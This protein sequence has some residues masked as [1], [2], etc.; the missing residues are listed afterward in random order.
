MAVYYTHTTRARTR[1]VQPLWS[2]ATMWILFILGTFHIA[3][4]INFFQRMWIDKRDLPGGPLQW[5]IES[6]G[7]PVN[8]LSSA[9]GPPIHLV[10]DAALVRLSFARL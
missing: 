5:L 6:Y 3:G 2:T 8:T 1:Q 7:D 10:Q 4:A 9:S